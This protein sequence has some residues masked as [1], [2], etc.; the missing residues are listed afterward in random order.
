MILP[1]MILPYLSRRRSPL[2]IRHLSRHAN[3]LARTMDW[4]RYGARQ[5]VSDVAFIVP[6][7]Y[8]K[9]MNFNFNT[10]KAIE[11]ACRLIEK[12]GQTINVMKL[13]KL[14]YLIDR[15]SIQRR[16]IP[17]V[18]GTY[19]SMRNGPVTSELLDLVN[20]GS[21][22][23]LPSCD[24][25][26]FISDRQNHEVSLAQKPTYEHLAEA[27]LALIDEVYDQHGARDQWQLRDWCHEHCAEWTPLE[28]GRDRISLEC[29]AEA[30][31]KTGD[32]VR[33]LAEGAAELNLLDA[34]FAKA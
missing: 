26:K 22:W 29:L 31:G 16:G 34:A 21:L 33:R 10:A 19:F 27:E 5:H 32:D 9:S 14:V 25:E 8:K 7:A 28:E 13:V 12:E 17:V 24:W 6:P 1:K 18:G 2:G 3:D 4:P 23:G 30:V 15:L 20:A 11:T